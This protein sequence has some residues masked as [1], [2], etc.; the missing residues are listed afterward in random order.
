MRSLAI[1]L[2]IWA[3]PVKACDSAVTYVSELSL[4]NATMVLPKDHF[5]FALPDMTDSDG[6]VDMSSCFDYLCDEVDNLFLAQTDVALTDLVI[7]VSATE[8]PS[9]ADTDVVQYFQSNHLIDG[10]CIWDTF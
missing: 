2:A 8:A 4:L 7:F 6:F 10:V 3:A 5:R 9:G 1:I